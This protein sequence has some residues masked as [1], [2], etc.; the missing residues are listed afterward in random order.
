MLNPSD[1]V[2]RNATEAYSIRY[3]NEQQDY[4]ADMLFP[5]SPETQKDAIKVWQY[6]T[7]QYRVSTVKKGSKAVADRVDYSGFYTNITLELRKL[8]GEIDPSDERNFDPVVNNLQEDMAA[9]IMDRLLIAKEAEAA[10][11]AT[12]SGNYPSALTSTLGA[13]ATWAVAGG[14]PEADSQTAR[15]AVKGTC[16]KM[17]NA[18]AISWTGFEYLKNS[19]ALKDRVKYTSG[20]SLSV[21]QIKNLLQVQYLFIGAA[22]KNTNLEGNATQSLSDIWDDSAIFFVYDPS[23]RKKKVSYGVQPIHNRLYSYQF[24]DEQRGSE[25]GRIKVLEMGWR[26]QLFAGAVESSS[27]TKFAAGYLLKNVY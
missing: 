26:Y 14:D 4:I 6:D 16:G 20:Q 1:F 11:L 27:S 2:T 3:A 12:T 22:Q 18:L 13:A 19:P 7:S 25:D 17:A 23:P 10:T 9:T 5:P 15:V 8:A 24:N 21:D